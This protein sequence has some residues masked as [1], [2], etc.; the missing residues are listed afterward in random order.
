MNSC[1]LDIKVEE[2]GAAK[3][4][5]EEAVSE[6]EAPDKVHQ[7]IKQEENAERKETEEAVKETKEKILTEV[8]GEKEAEEEKEAE[9]KEEVEKVKEEKSEEREEE[10]E[11]V[12]EEKIKEKEE[13]KVEVKEEVKS[14]EEK[15]KV[16]KEE[17]IIEE[18]EEE[19]QQEPEQ[20]QEQE[21]EQEPEQEQEEDMGKCCS[22]IKTYDT[23]ESEAEVPEEIKKEK[24]GNDFEEERA[25]LMEYI[26][27]SEMVKSCCIVSFPSGQ[28]RVNFPDEFVPNREGIQYVIEGFQGKPENLIEHG[29]SLGCNLPNITPGSYDEGEAL[30]SIDEATQIGCAVVKTNQCLLFVVFEGQ[31]APACR[32]A[33]ETGKLMKERGL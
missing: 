29:I 30:Y 21:P 12:K 2:E 11:E 9:K 15:P 31:L 5:V 28:I 27:E 14:E 25:I 22:C 18:Q 33:S 10:I 24:D 19:Q 23:L 6:K 3:G 8:K 13:E 1:A 7:E 26:V 32:L 16:V 17:A 20:E 4:E